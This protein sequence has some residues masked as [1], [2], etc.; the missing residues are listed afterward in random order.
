MAGPF[1]GDSRAV[2]PSVGYSSDPLQD[3]DCHKIYMLLR[4]SVRSWILIERMLSAGLGSGSPVSTE[5]KRMMPH[6]DIESD[7]G[8]ELVG[9]EHL[10]SRV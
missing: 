6:C 10:A 4:H 8:E 5:K 7:C 2:P 1:D 3:V 9:G